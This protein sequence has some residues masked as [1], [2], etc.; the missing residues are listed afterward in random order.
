MARE[1]NGNTDN[2][3]KQQLTTVLFQ[4][5]TNIVLAINKHVNLSPEWKLLLQ[6]VSGAYSTILTQLIL[7]LLL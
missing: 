6:L 3:F 2:A 7:I 4:V 1:K 5:C